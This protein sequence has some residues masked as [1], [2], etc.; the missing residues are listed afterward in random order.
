MYHWYQEAEV[1]Y[2]YLADVPRDAI[3]HLT[4]PADSNFSE[5][6]W[7]TRGWTLQELIAP[8]TVI[9]LDR[10]WQEIGT[11]SSM[12]EIISETTGISVGILLGDDIGL[13][14]VAQRMSWASKMKTTR[15]EDL[16]Y[17]LM[18]IFG[19][20]MPMLYGEGERAFVRLQEEI[21][22]ISDDHSLF[23]WKLKSEEE[24]GG[25]LATSPAAFTQSGNIVQIKPSDTI[26]NP[27]ATSSKRIHLSVHLLNRGQQGLGLA[28]LNCTENKKDHLR[29]AIYVRDIS[30]AR[31]Y[32]SRERSDKLELLD[33][34]VFNLLKYPLET[35]CVQRG[36][37]TRKGKR[38]DVEKY[39]VKL[40]G[41]KEHSTAL[42]GVHQHLRWDP[43]NTLVIPITPITDG[44]FD[45]VLVLCKDGTWFELSLKKCGK[46]VLANIR[47]SS[48]SSQSLDIYREPEHESDRITQKFNDERHLEV[49]I[50]KQIHQT[51]EQ[52][53]LVHVVEIIYHSPWS[54]SEAAM[55]HDHIALV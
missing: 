28:I 50:K 54:S 48:V 2:A 26:G 43:S 27:L 51:H 16:A 25:L 39:A 37:L 49:M 10:E 36:S 6:R 21:M 4:K 17:C 33:T 42:S 46:L 52:N 30:L 15:V 20:Y 1:C 34:T 35:I 29:I 5:S 22:K 55:W 14:S 23:A 8:S 53:C 19:I 13:A 9:F 11:K 3:D 44:V 45:R 7:F 47:T 32:F 24:H 12:Q 40:M 41:T 38:S 18:G 31:K